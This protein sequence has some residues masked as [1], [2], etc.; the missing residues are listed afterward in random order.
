M[1]GYPSTPACLW[2]ERFCQNAL[3][4]AALSNADQNR[5]IRHQVFLVKLFAGTLGN[6]GSALVA[7]FFHQLGQIAFD[8]IQYFIGVSK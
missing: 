3:D 5:L 6:M 1:T 7:V 2:S 4:I 8:N